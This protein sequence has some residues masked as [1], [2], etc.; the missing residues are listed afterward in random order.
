[1]KP[2]ETADYE[3]ELRDKIKALGGKA[4]GRSSIERLEEQLTELECGE[5]VEQ[6]PISVVCR[7]F[8]ISP[9]QREIDGEMVEGTDDLIVQ[10]PANLS[11]GQAKRKLWWFAQILYRVW[12]YAK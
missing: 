10:F 1:M 4:G 9:N 5:S 11:A 12:K 3:R 8:T 7:K 2:E 6:E